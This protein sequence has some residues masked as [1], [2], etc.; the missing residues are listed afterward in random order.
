MIIDT[1]Y[2]LTVKSYAKKHNYTRQQIYKYIWAKII[3]VIEIDGAIFIHKDTTFAIGLKKI[4][5]K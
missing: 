5:E 2:Y 4:N 1:R 3:P